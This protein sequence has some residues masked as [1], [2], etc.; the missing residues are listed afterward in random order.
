[1]KAFSELSMREVAQ[2]IYDFARNNAEQVVE[3]KNNNGD[4]DPRYDY[5]I[6]TNTWVCNATFSLGG[7]EMRVDADF[8]CQTVSEVMNN[9]KC[10][11]LHVQY[12]MGTPEQDDIYNAY[13]SAIE[14]ELQKIAGYD[15]SVC[16]D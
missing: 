12:V 2:E 13:C 4:R 7:V 6:S 10:N 9:P 16:V 14:Y 15:C 5:E 3:T 8:V 11:Y 1:M